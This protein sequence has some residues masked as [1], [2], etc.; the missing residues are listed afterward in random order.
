MARV[1]VLEDDLMFLSRV[2]EAARAGAVE[3]EVVRGKAAL[4]DACRAQAPALL[5]AN[6][7]SPRLGAAEAIRALKAEPG[8]AGVQ[9]VGFLS[10]VR[11]DL[12][13][14]AREAG[15]DRVLA[16]SGF[17]QELPRLLEAASRIQ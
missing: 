3:L 13:M 5:L 12:A 7:D 4:L 11:A 2:R 6:L 17:V 15:C 1:V 10:H 14:A 8:L 9:V 16:R